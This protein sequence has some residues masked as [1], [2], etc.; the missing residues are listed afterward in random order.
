MA[1]DVTFVVL[2]NVIN[3]EFF[4]G[5]IKIFSLDEFCGSSEKCLITFFSVEFIMR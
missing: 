4:F 3:C 5:P 1:H 2:C